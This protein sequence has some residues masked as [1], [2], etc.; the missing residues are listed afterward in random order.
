MILLEISQLLEVIIGEVLIVMSS[1]RTFIQAENQENK[2]WITTAMESLVFHP[3]EKLI[4]RNSVQD[5]KDLVLLSLEI[6]QEPISQSQKNTSTH[7]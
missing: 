1:I 7:Q 2:F 6:Q 5:L 4:N 3:R